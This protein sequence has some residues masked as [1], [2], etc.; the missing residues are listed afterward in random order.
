MNCCV[1]VLVI[2]S[3]FRLSNTDHFTQHPVPNRSYQVAV[4]GMWNVHNTKWVDILPLIIDLEEPVDLGGGYA[5]VVHLS[6][7]L[8]GFGFVLVI[9]FVALGWFWLF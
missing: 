6:L 8:F 3:L 1:L 5:E 2:V 4:N 7:Y 9:C